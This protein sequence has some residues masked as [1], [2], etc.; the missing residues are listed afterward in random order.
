MYNFLSLLIGSLIAV[1]AAFNGILSSKAGSY[2][3]LLIIHLTGYIFILII[4]LLKRER[5]PFKMKHSVYLYSA[6]AISVATV[7]INNITF[8]NIGISLPVALSLLGQMAASIFFDYFGF[9]DMPKI[10]FNKKKTIGFVIITAGIC[11]MTFL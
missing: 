10:P 7:L 2:S 6:G 11:I 3:S 1:M 9:L 4:M 5:I 8:A